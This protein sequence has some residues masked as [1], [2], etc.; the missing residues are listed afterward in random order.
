MRHRYGRTDRV[1][2]VR[3]KNMTGEIT[4]EAK[5][6][7]QPRDS[8]DRQGLQRADSGRRVRR[9][10]IRHTRIRWRELQ[11][12]Y[13]SAVAAYVCAVMRSR[14]K[15]WPIRQHQWL[16]ALVYE[17]WILLQPSRCFYS[18]WLA[19]VY[20]QTILLRIDYAMGSFLPPSPD[21]LSVPVAF[22]QTRIGAF[23][24]S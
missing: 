12:F 21:T 10:P 23:S 8:T 19:V 4:G 2:E 1:D 6:G 13:T 7:R 22:V 15:L 14:G 3:W 24:L 16:C 17:G 9:L 5:C 20:L 11:C 18:S